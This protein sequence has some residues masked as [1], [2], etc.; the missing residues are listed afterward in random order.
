MCHVTTLHTRNC[1]SGPMTQPPPPTQDDPNDPDVGA[2]VTLDA[3]RR[4]NLTGVTPHSRFLMT[5]TDG[6]ITLTP[7]I[8]MP[9]S[10]YSKILESADLPNPADVLAA[11]A[12]GLSPRVRTVRHD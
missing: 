7:A 10:M 1:Y 8:V 9:V 2:V 12:S 5:I 6:V 11:A 4:L 3:R